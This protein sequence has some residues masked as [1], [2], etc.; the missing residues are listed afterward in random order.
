MVASR[1]V[2]ACAS[3]RPSIG[4]MAGAVPPA[5]MT[6]RRASSVVVADHDPALAVD[7]AP[8]ADERDAA[9][10]E[11]RQLRRVV[12][13][14]DHLVAAAQHGGRVE[15]AAR[16]LRARRGCAAPPPA[17]RPAAAAPSTAC[18]P[19]TSTRRR[20]CGPRRWRPRAPPPRAARPPP[21][22]PA[23]HRPPPRRTSPCRSSLLADSEIPSQDTAGIRRAGLLRRVLSRDPNEA[24]LEAPR[25]P[26]TMEEHPG[27]DRLRRGRFVGAVASRGAGGLVKPRQHHKCEQARIRSRCLANT[28]SEPWHP[29]PA[30]GGCRVR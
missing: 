14:V 12:E 9:V 1:F 10:L 17:P 30:P 7:P 18:T 28:R 4:G 29:E 20:P 21:H 6:A 11:P 23:L 26:P 24:G 16:R 15:L 8:A 25:P 22:R 5:R 27:D 3:A 19:R 2:Q 13:V